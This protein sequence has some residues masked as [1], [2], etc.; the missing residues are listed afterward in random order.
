MKAFK[1]SMMGVVLLLMGSCSS[2]S[3][4]NT[5]GGRNVSFLVTDAPM[6]YS[7]KSVNVQI[8]GIDYQVAADSAW[9]TLTPFNAGVYD[10]EALTNGL[11]RQLGQIQLPNIATI[12]NI[13]LNLGT[14][15]TV[16]LA[17]DSTRPLTIWN[18]QSS[19]ILHINQNRIT[20]SGDSIMVDFNLARSIMLTRTGYILKPVLRGYIESQTTSIYGYITPDTLRCKVE[21]D[22]FIISNGD[23]ISTASDVNHMNFFRLSGLPAGTY[24]I[25]IVPV[26]STK[27]PFTL[28]ITINQNG[29]MKLDKFS[30]QWQNL[31]WNRFFRL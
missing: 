15:N 24:T 13:R 27:S 5:T 30:P 20:A 14:D 26:N 21:Y 8:T 17:N 23:T 4:N 7:F 19:V 28:E 11:C 3:S 29:I 1:F 18:N 16:V 31:L 25:Q 12:R 2:N 10:L 22:V 6:W 9:Q